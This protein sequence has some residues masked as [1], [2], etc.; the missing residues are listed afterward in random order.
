MEVTAAVISTGADKI[1]EDV[2]GV[3]GA[4]QLAHG[5]PQA[6]GKVTGQ[7]ITEVTGGNGEIHIIPQCDPACCQQVMVTALGVGQ[8]GSKATS[9]G[10]FTVL[11]LPRGVTLEKFLSF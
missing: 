10:F 1:S 9:P 3:T 5:K 6:L 2:V 4:D 7:N 8:W 11:L